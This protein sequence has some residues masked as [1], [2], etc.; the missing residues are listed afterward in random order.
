MQTSLQ[1][2]LLAYYYYYYLANPF[3]QVYHNFSIDLPEDKSVG[4]AE[5]LQL[6]DLV[7]Q[8]FADQVRAGELS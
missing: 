4:L 5:P 3:P 6:G 8:F 2:L 7:Q 1:L